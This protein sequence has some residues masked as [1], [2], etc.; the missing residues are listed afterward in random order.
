MEL[1]QS[2]TKPSICG[3]RVRLMNDNYNHKWCVF[4]IKWRSPWLG[5]SDFA[6]SWMIQ[7]MSHRSATTNQLYRLNMNKML[8]SSIILLNNYM[9]CH[10]VIFLRQF[11]Y[12]DIRFLIFS[13]GYISQAPLEHYWHRI[14]KHD[15]V[16]NT[17]PSLP[18]WNMK[19]TQN[20]MVLEITLTFF[21]SFRFLRDCW[22]RVL[23]F[24]H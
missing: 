17:W 3:T 13:K 15:H 23:R 1:L 4:A 16:T 14:N 2:C 22:I 7:L 21:K 6:D 19:A 24:T 11:G 12:L 20:I 8:W 9:Y 10:L 5:L 18:I